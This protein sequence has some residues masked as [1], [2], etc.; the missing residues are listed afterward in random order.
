MNT[1]ITNGQVTLLYDEV[2]IDSYLLEA[3]KM[4]AIQQGDLIPG[5]SLTGNDYLQKV[6][7][8]ADI[9]HDIMESVLLPDLFDRLPLKKNGE[10]P[11]NRTIPVFADQTIRA[12]TRNGRLEKTELVLAICTHETI[13]QDL[14]DLGCRIDDDGL[15]N[16]TARLTII[17]KEDT[18]K[19]VPL[20][21]ANL[22]ARSAKPKNLPRNKVVPGGIYRDK[23]GT[24][25]LYL[26][27]LRL[28]DRR[29]WARAEPPYVYLKMTPAAYELF[30][31]ASSLNDFISQWLDA[32]YKASLDTQNKLS[33]RQS[34]L[35]FVEAVNDAFVG[36]NLTPANDINGDKSAWKP[37][38]SISGTDIFIVTGTKEYACDVQTLYL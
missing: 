26:G 22:N 23:H 37:L 28:M 38:C 4:Q 9:A 27:T 12:T 2:V 21:D 32:N 36:D 14:I 6:R 3:F 18:R 1:E 13:S 17:E 34:P 15:D 33:W 35:S 24:D 29:D 7:R 11:V 16:T 5:T 25:Y 10:Y 8:M 31:N 20:L 30:N 19:L